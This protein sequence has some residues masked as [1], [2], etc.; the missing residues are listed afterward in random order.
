M[1][2]ENLSLQCT[3]CVSILRDNTVHQVYVSPAFPVILCD[4]PV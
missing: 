1:Y 2:L 4:I 3:M